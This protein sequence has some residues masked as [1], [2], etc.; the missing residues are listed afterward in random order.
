MNSF[1][2]EID[3]AT[4]CSIS[5]LAEDMV[6]RLPGCA[7]IMIRKE[8][9]KAY[10]DFCRL[11]VALTG[12][13]EIPIEDGETVYYVF[14]KFARTQVYSVRDVWVDGR[15]LR[16]G[17]YRFIHGD[18]IAIAPNVSLEG[19]ET[20]RVAIQHVPMY[21]EE[22]APKWFID[23]YGQAIVAGAL[24]RLFAMTGKAWSDTNQAKTEMVT[25]ENYLTEARVDSV[26]GGTKNGHVEAIDTSTL[27]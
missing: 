18:M 17:D 3:V 21:G 2:K 24:S 20:L 4:P 14:P 8:L 1:Q 16:N 27:L 7:N 6:Y 10:F 11:S 15:R 12:E 5:E 25:W 26:T 19:R 9:Q 13:I 22:D 23:R